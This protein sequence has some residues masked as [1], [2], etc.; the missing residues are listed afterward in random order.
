MFLLLL[1]PAAA[2]S[3]SEPFIEWVTI[4]DPG[5]AADDTGFGAVETAYRIGK[6]EVTV[7]QYVEFLNA[8]AAS[9]PLGL[10]PDGVN[11]GIERSGSPGSYTY[12]A[13]L[14]SLPVNYV[15][16]YDALRFVNW[17]HNG[18]D[19]WGHGDW[20][21]HAARGDADTEQR[22]H[23]DAQP[24]GQ[25]GRDSSRCVAANSRADILGRLLRSGP[26]LVVT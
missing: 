5:N 7:G 13:P 8:K 19:K 9:D 4:G 10:Y 12:V 25:A 3:Q 22:R 15:D 11:S 23:R 6:F 16:F 21:L 1:L 14:G 18:R 2:L 17:L 20:G 26:T 24:R